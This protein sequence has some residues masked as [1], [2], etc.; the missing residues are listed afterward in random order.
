MRVALPIAEG[1]A[2]AGS[3]SSSASI[4]SS[5]ASESLK[6]SGPKNLMPLSW[7]GLC[8]AEIITPRSARIERA[9]M[10]TAGVGTGPT[11]KTF[12]PTEVKPAVSAFSSM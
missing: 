3:A 10:P 6:P 4:S 7:N 5:A 2:S 8:E 11:R 1:S 9:S 12:M